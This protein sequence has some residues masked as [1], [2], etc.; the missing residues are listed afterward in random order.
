MD[1]AITDT[2]LANLFMRIKAFSET[3]GLILFIKPPKWGFH[4][5][6]FSHFMKGAIGATVRSFFSRWQ[7]LD[8]LPDFADCCFHNGNGAREFLS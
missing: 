8:V 4:E 6:G 3:G 7:E 5:V 2:C 1:G